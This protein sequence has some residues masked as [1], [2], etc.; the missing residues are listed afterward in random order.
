MKQ[1][2]LVLRLLF[3]T[4][5]GLL[6]MSDVALLPQIWSHRDK[7]AQ[8]SV[9]LFFALVFILIGVLCLKDA[10]KIVLILRGKLSR[11]SMR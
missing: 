10:V 1:S 6:C 3:E 2:L 9:E 5:L 11:S 8:T 7:L 4:V